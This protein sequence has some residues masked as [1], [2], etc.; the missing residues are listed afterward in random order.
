MKL[1]LSSKTFIAIEFFLQ[2]E[3]QY[4]QYMIIRKFWRCKSYGINEYEEIKSADLYRKSIRIVSQI[5]IEKSIIINSDAHFCC[6]KAER[7]VDFK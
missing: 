7:Y 1:S 5:C 4:I 6:S 2:Y 3:L